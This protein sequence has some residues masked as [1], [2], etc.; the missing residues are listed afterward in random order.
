M[1]N[2]SFS[3][4]PLRALVLLGMGLI[5]FGAHAAGYDV[6]AFVT[7]HLGTGAA[8][9]AGLGGLAFMGETAD[10]KIMEALDRV[11]KKMGEA[12]EKATAEIKELGKVT[13]ETKSTI[14]ALG[15]EQ[16]ALADRLLAIEQKASS[17]DQVEPEVKSAGELFIETTQYKNFVS[18]N[19][20]GKTH[21]EVKNT[22]TNA[23]ANTYSE[24]RPGLVEG[25]W[26]VFTIENLLTSIPTTSNAIDWIQ[27]STFVNNAAEVAEGSAKPQSSITFVPKTSPV[28]TIAHWIRI[29]KQLASDNAALA[30]YINRRMIYGVN[31]R[32]ESQIVSGNGAA[33]NLG[34]L[35]MAGNFT[36]HGYTASL[37]SAQGLA[38]NRFDVIGKM[39]G[40]CAAADYPAD[41]IMLSIIDWWIIRLQKDSTGRYLMGDPSSSAPPMLFG[42][43]VVASNAVPTGKVWVGSLAQAVTLHEREGVGIALSD[44]DADN[45]TN[46]LITIRAERRVALTVEKP[47]AC[48]YGDLVPA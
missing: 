29:T 19:L 23:V 24:R 39:I 5:A 8:G 20:Q 26:R 15:N 3:R 45:F 22:V 40:D 18:G 47:A 25:A 14:D 1:K 28:Q 9:M 41:V 36:P 27:E 4:I 46:N 12:S 38:N 30:A 11:E 7:A 43:P 37:L 10:A 6:A 2:F 35:T 42:L 32:V 33:P 31:M 16:K 44:S 48:R 13:Q 34:G 21:A 17:E